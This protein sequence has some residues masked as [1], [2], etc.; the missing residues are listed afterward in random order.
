MNYN[1]E[2]SL[3][4]RF[5]VTLFLISLILL[6]DLLVAFMMIGT[7]LMILVDLLAVMSLWN[8]PFNALS[9]TN[10]IMAVGVAVGFVAHTAKV[11]TVRSGRGDDRAGGALIEL[12]S[13]LFRGMTIT[14]LIGIC[15]L[16]FLPNAL[17]RIY[18]F[19]MFLTITIVSAL[20]GL[21]FFPVTLSYLG[22]F[23]YHRQLVEVPI[24]DVNDGD[25]EI[26][27]SMSGALDE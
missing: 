14:K 21:V 12:A 20:H 11:F 24:I 15:V 2:Y 13:G 5:L 8:I 25:L 1:R 4:F 16:A 22:D 23:Y 10:L 7:L 27:S 17:F 6:G 26:D 3:I 19:R 18:Y 9:A